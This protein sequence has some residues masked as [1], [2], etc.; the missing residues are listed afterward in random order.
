MQQSIRIP[1][2]GYLGSATLLW[3]GV[4][5]ALLAGCSRPISTSTLLSDMV[6]LDRLCEM[7]CPVYK[8]EQASSWD[9]ASKQPGTPE[10]FANND[11]SQ[12]IR[13]EECDGRKEWVMMDAAGP[14]A[15]VRIWSANPKGNI[16]IYLDGN[17]KPLVDTPMDKLLGGNYPG[18]PS[19]I[20]GERG[21]GWNVYFPVAYAKHCK[22]TCDTD[23]FYYHVNYRTYPA[24]T[25]VRTLTGQEF[26]RLEQSGRIQAVADF[27]DLPIPRLKRISCLKRVRARDPVSNNIQ[28]AA[29]SEATIAE[30]NGPAQIVSF[31]VQLKA[32]DDL[33]AALRQVILY[34]EFD[35]QQT[36]AAPLGDFFGTA[37]GLSEYK[38]LPLK[39][40]ADTQSM[41]C[42]WRMPFARNARLSLKNMGSQPVELDCSYVTRPYRWT[43]RSLLF[44]AKWRI[45]KDIPTRPFTDWTHLKCSGSGRF[46]GGTLH[47]INPVRIWWGE[48]DEKI[49]IDGE[50]FPS[51]FGTGSEDY[52]GYAWGSPQV[53]VH[54]YHNQ[55][56]CDGPDNYGHTLLNRFHILD[57][58]PFTTQFQFD[59]ENWHHN[60]AVKTT[61]AATSYW[62]ARPGGTDFFPPITREDVIPVTVPEYVVKVVPGA[63]EGES[64]PILAKSG[65]PQ[66]QSMDE[67]YSKGAHLWWRDAKPG[68]KLVLGFDAPEAG[69][70]RVIVRLTKAID[71][72]IVQLSVNDHKAGEPIDLFND[73][74]IPTDEIDLGV[75]PLQKGQN[76]L[77]V[78]IV[79]AND[80]AQKAH[81]FGL[82][83]LLLK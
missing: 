18:L 66:V 40:S 26:K 55:P 80:K 52:Y 62:Y 23:G 5:I 10:W 81:M 67:R 1:H 14:G 35:G 49:Y 42:V 76:T 33:A 36:I 9:R 77:T 57:D 22:V 30:L 78:E 19:P 69:D 70:K 58:M 2:R 46:V 54:A 74:V 31:N 83:Y 79:G 13:V 34:G 4:V 41:W 82:D 17:P 37:A 8:C 48:G 51:T 3:L 16:R 68:D 72:G 38:S 64:L 6:D 59:M 73:G 63:I 15:I 45:E 32:A 71:Y 28:L 27:L 53:F 12:F 75:F 39:I 56:R 29:D 47:L 21:R 50:T 65:N 25:N 11:F 60:G 20:A 7:P 43:S 61:R 44:H 24:G